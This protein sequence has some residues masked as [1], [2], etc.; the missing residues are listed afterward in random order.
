MDH[1]ELQLLKRSDPARAVSVARDLLRTGNIPVTELAGILVDIGEDRND[2]AM[3]TEGL[4]ALQADH[5][6]APQSDKRYLI[7]TAYQ[8]VA[9][10]SSQVGAEWFEATKAD[11]RTARA[12]LANA[13]L[14]GTTEI[15]R[16]MAWINL[17]N[18]LS[19]AGRV[20]EAYACFKRALPNPVAAGWVAEALFIAAENRVGDPTTLLPL[21]HRYAKAAQA[22]PRMVEGIVGPEVVELFGTYPTHLASE[23]LPADRG[24]TAEDE[25]VLSHRLHL[26]TAIDGAHP[27]DWDYLYLPGLTV[28]MDAPH[29]PPPLIAMVNICKADLRLARKL[30]FS[31]QSEDSVPSSDS[32]LYSDTLDN[33]SYGERTAKVTMALRSGLDVLDRVAVAANQYFGFGQ[34][35]RKVTFQSVWRKRQPGGPLRDLIRAEIEAGNRGV[36]ALVELADDI[37]SE[38]W[39][40]DRR[41]LR[42]TATHRFLIL[43]DFGIGTHQECE[44][45]EHVDFDSTFISAASAIGLARSGLIYLVNAVASR[46]HRLHHLDGTKYVRLE[47]PSHDQIRGSA[48][49]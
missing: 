22:E 14:H 44:E 11:R 43:H 9:K 10:A 27:R 12:H 46:E 17:G 38:G 7:G 26:S 1:R 48:A 20:D 23:V 28:P 42:N 2:S 35:V 18:D 34:A 31:A 15:I 13:A 47:L 8:S 41:A 30:L 4:N 3:V 25:F 24:L 49:C 29:E 5:E 32:R 21:A 19:H 33:A 36:L 45:I 37:A 16:Q 39:L 6:Q 40:S